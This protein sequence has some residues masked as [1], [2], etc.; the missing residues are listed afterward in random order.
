MCTKRN[1]TQWQI[2]NLSRQ[3]DEEYDRAKWQEMKYN[4]RREAEGG[5]RNVFGAK[6][7][8]D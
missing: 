8:M 3:A 4:E 7:K 6:L 5:K 1:I 2:V